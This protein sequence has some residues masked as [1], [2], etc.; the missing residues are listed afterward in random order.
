MVWSKNITVK[1]RGVL[2]CNGK[3]N[4]ERWDVLNQGASYPFWIMDGENIAIRDI[5]MRNSG[6]WSMHCHYC[7]NFTL[8]NYKVINPR[9][10]GIFQGWW[11]DG[12]NISCGQKVLCEDCFAYC[13][14]D[15]F[16]TGQHT[17]E[18]KRKVTPVYRVVAADSKD[19]VIRNLF[20]LTR[21]GNAIR[22]GCQSMGYSIKNSR[23]EN[24]DFMYTGRGPHDTDIL[25]FRLKGGIL[26]MPQLLQR[27]DGVYENIAFVDCS[28]ENDNCKNYILSVGTRIHFT[29]LE[30]LRCTF[31]FKNGGSIRGVDELNVQDFKS[32]GVVRRDA[33]DAGIELKDVKKVQW[34]TTPSR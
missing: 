23:F 31:D 25:F 14:D 3:A 26:E 11:T 28:W 1:G 27:R 34:S 33:R 20:G 16:A 13:C 30:L 29:K 15:V 8:S 18:A 32:A 19:F 5:F 12:M 9:E 22:F 7:R 17:Y 24:C 21:G 2:D 6:E 4:R 10:S